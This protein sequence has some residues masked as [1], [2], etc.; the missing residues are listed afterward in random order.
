[1]PKFR[2][3]N[4]IRSKNFWQIPEIHHK[5]DWD[6]SKTNFANTKQLGD[7][8]MLW[9]DSENLKFESFQTKHATHMCG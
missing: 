8:S 6:K 7:V 9:N 5:V 3:Q 4:S 2:I 1:M